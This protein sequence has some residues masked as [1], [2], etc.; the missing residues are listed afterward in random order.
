MFLTIVFINFYQNSD[1]KMKKRP[2]ENCF[3][4]PFFRAALTGIAQ[5]LRHAVDGQVNH[6]QGVRIVGLFAQAFKHG[7]L[8]AVEGVQIWN[9]QGKR[10][11]EAAV[12][13]Q[14]LFGL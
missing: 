3:R 12:V 8:Q 11:G 4:R 1:R 5:T 7:D 6:Q 9:P 14:E 2:S 10:T 13:A